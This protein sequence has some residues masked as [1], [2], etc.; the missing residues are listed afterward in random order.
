[1]RTIFVA[2]DEEN[3]KI[4]EGE[5]YME[6]DVKGWFSGKKYN[7]KIFPSYSRINIFKQKIN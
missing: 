5:T 2:Y 3:K 4:D 6:A 7:I 1:M